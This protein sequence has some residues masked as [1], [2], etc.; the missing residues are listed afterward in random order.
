MTSRLVLM[1][2]P[3]PQTPSTWSR[4]TFLETCHGFETGLVLDN[5]SSKDKVNI[6]YKISVPIAR[7]TPNNNKHLYVDI[8]GLLYKS[9]Y[10]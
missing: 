5:G 1:A 9:P 2:Y 6:V 8:D 3:S 4:R 7:G 10:N